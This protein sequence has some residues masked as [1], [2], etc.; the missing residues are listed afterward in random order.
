MLPLTPRSRLL[1]H[2]Y[3]YLSCLRVS[4]LESRK[5]I[6]HD[7]H[8][9]TTSN[10]LSHAHLKRRNGLSCICFARGPSARWRA[11]GQREELLCAANS[12]RAE[13]VHRLWRTGRVYSYSVL[14]QVE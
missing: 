11:V 3:R 7:A 8:T 5:P 10:R 1:A 14:D 13:H 4:F 2:V 9:T 6:A 12:E